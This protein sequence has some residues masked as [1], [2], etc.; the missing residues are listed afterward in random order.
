MFLVMENSLT[1]ILKKKYG[2]NYRRVIR[3]I[4]SALSSNSRVRWTIEKI[5]EFK[6]LIDWKELS[7]NSN[8]SWTASLLERY[9]N[10]LDWERLSYNSSEHLF[11]A[12]NLRQFSSEWDWSALSSINWTIEKIEEFKDLIDWE[13]LLGDYDCSDA[14]RC[15]PIEFFEKYA[16]YIPASLLNDESYLWRAIKDVYTKRLIEDI[17]SHC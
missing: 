17:F 10:K 9:K 8:V 5:E 16:N 13:E 7:G 11:S 3:L 15:N 6:D 2:K 14:Y 1:Q 12:E 4:S